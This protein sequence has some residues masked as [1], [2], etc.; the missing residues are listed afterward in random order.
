LA[1]RIAALEARPA[2]APTVRWR[3]IWKRG[4]PYL[5]GHLVTR[6]GSLWLSTTSTPSGSAP[7]HG[8]DFVLICKN[9]AFRMEN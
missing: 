5:E 4:E 8:D 3:G 2:N 6:N 1:E 7:G 9:G